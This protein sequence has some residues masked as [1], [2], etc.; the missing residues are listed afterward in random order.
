MKKGISLIV[1][2][3][4][5]IV[6]II[7]AA[8]VVITLSNTNI[9]NRADQAVV[10]TNLNQVQQL[11]T[12]IWSEAYIDEMENLDADYIRAKLRENKI[13][14]TKY[15]IIVKD[16]G[17]SVI[18]RYPEQWKTSVSEVTLDG[19]P[20][21]KGFVKSPYPN[22]GNKNEGLVIYALTEQEIANGVTDITTVDA[23]HKVSLENR[24][25]FVW[26]PVNSEKFASEFVR[27][28]FGG[29]DVNNKE[30]YELSNNVEGGK[31]YW[32]VILENNNF[33]ADNEKN[34]AAHVS[35]KTLKEV[36]AMYASVKKYGGFY[37][38]RYEVGASGVESS[39]NYGRGT[40]SI[41]MTKYPYNNIYWG[42]SMS[43]EELDGGAVT[44]ARSFYPETNTKYGAVS[45]LMYGVQWDRTLAW[46]KEMNPDI[47]LDDSR[48]Y[49]VHA[50]TRFE[51]D[52]FNEGARYSPYNASAYHGWYDAQAKT[53]DASWLV[54][55]GGYEK[56]KVC[57][58]YDMAGNLYEWTMEGQ[59]VSNR[60]VRGGYVSAAG[61]YRSV[62]DRY[63]ITPQYASSY[64][65]G[66]RPALYI[67]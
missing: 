54:T 61:E 49:G 22:E 4:T 29:K 18:D 42:T 56:S 33:P 46:W 34:S 9:I 45:T 20:I 31:K 5:I 60:V 19:V 28:T 55:T 47:S 66:L 32:E 13:D 2:V 12:L 65:M 17:V 38:G 3:I 50:N 53:S 14:D 37:V 24:N 48:D 44:V 30:D 52:D 21:P 10:A 35:A 40:L 51:Q 39:T 6:M 11:A 16:S 36:T 7:L 23:S 1:L 64:C 57:N 59:G 25:Q 8:T 62:I 63:A 67:K 41:T 15:A 58:I 26:V 43:N 27:Q